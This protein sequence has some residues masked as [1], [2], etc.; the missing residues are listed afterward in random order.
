MKTQVEFEKRTIHRIISNKRTSLTQVRIIN[1]NDTLSAVSG[2]QIPVVVR[3]VGL[4]G[5]RVELLLLD[6]WYTSPDRYF[7]TGVND[8]GEKWL[9]N[10]FGRISPD[11]DGIFNEAAKG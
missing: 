1:N 6:T 5:D 2:W 3:G 7:G 9:I 10:E 11:P 4:N 8:I